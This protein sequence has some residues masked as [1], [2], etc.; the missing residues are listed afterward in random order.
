MSPTDVCL[1]C[2]ATA[3]GSVFGYDP[4]APA[5]EHG[6][7]NFI[8]LLEDNIN[9][10]QNGAQQPLAGEAAGHSIVAP[11]AGLL[12]DSR[13][14]NAPG[15]TYPA[16]ELGCTSCHDPHGNSNF[17]MLHGAGGVQGGD[18]TF[19]A[20]APSAAGVDLSGGVE[21]SANHTAYQGGWAAWCGNCHGADYHEFGQGHF[22]HPAEPALAASIRDRYDAYLGDANP[23]GGAASTSYL[24]EVPFEDPAATTSGTSG[25]TTI[26]R[27]SC[28][29]CH[30]AH[31]TSA[32]ASGRWDWNVESLGEDGAVS[33]SYAIPNPY[34]DPLQRSLCFKCH[35]IDHDNG[36]SC[37]NCHAR[38]QAGGVKTPDP[39]G[40]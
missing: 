29:S 21:N 25:P 18:Y 39:A 26:S 10:R 2:H 5:T 11:G 19:S 22:E 32:T 33:G 3:N 31:A 13:Y 28:I 14:G 35:D 17:R 37:L 40:N 4:L 15:G 38:G 7:G 27:L 20:P 6:G 8:F 24:P 9:D 36:K 30:R 16:S 12:P 34:T 23:N 1:S